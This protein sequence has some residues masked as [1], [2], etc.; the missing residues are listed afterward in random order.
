M[1]DDTRKQLEKIMEEARSYKR[2]SNKSAIYT[3]LKGS[4]RMLDLTPIEYEFAIYN[5]SRELRF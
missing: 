4:V 1:S 5:L 3:N 2:N